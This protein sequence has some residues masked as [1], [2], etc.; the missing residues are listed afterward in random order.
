MKSKKFHKT[1][2]GNGW[3]KKHD[4]S[5]NAVEAFKNGYITW[6]DF[7]KEYFLGEELEDLH[8]L[9]AHLYSRH[10]FG[11][12]KQEIYMFPKNILDI[13]GSENSDWKYF[14]E[15]Y[16]QEAYRIL[17][18]KKDVEERINVIKNAKNNTED[19]IKAKKNKC[20][21]SLTDLV[22]DY[23]DTEANATLWAMKIVSKEFS[24]TNK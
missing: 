18:M 14:M 7:D 11:K 2:R 5:N 17:D 22:S 3:N 10:H 9:V 19:D 4:M 1:K 20:L 16:P 8:F 21:S 12:N 23:F 13:I 24:E 6:N 15:D